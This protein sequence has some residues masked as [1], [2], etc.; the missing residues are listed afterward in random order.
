MLQN[1]GEYRL[2]GGFVD[3]KNFWIAVK[4]DMALMSKVF[5]WIFELLREDMDKLHEQVRSGYRNWW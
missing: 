3:F 2:A 4:E 1:R 5:L